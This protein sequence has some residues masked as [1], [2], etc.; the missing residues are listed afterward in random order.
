MRGTNPRI[1][2]NLR[3]TLA[4][5]DIVYRLDGLAQILQG[6]AGNPEFEQAAAMSII[7]EQMEE[8]SNELHKRYVPQY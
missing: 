1:N 3:G 8:I 5:E 7:A 4:L 6:F 2:G